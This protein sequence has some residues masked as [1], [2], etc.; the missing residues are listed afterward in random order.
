LDPCKRKRRYKDRREA[1]WAAN[2]METFLERSMRVYL[3]PACGGYHLTK[4]SRERYDAKNWERL[5]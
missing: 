5:T 1:V 2:R 4:M 3:C